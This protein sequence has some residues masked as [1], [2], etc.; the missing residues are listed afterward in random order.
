MGISF[1][2]GVFV[3]FGGRRPPCF[4]PLQGP[5]AS[6]GISA[7]DHSQLSIR[8]TGPFAIPK[9]PKAWAS[10]PSALLATAS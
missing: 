4:G 5:Q 6:L 8:A 2:A 3:R 9:F 10:R 7:Q 1:T